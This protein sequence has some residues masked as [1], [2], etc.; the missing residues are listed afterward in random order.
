MCSAYLDA[1][2]HAL[3]ECVMMIEPALGMVEMK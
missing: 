2:Q 1:Q 3:S